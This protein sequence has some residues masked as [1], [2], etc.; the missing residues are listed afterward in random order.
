MSIVINGSVRSINSIIRLIK[1]ID[2][3]IDGT[4]GLLLIYRQ[5]D[6][7]VVIGYLWHDCYWLASQPANQPTSPLP[8]PNTRNEGLAVAPWKRTHKTREQQQNLP[9]AERHAVYDAAR[10][11]PN[12]T[13]E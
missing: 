13:K 2:I 9:T 8:L 11:A 7:S 1:S 6:G 5:I 10:S 12:R 3:L 4:S